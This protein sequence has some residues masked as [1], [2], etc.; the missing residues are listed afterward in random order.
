VI[1]EALNIALEIRDAQG[2]FYAAG[3]LGVRAA[4]AGANEPAKQYLTMALNV[5]RQAGFPE[6]EKIEEELRKLG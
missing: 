5:G 6:T 3:A 1:S 2:I 4:Y